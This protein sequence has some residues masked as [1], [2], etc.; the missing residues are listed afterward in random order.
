MLKRLMKRGET[1]GRADDNVETIKK[2]FGAF[3][4]LLEPYYFLN[5][6]TPTATYKEATMP[7]IEHY[8]KQGKV[9]EVRLECSLSLACLI[10]LIRQIDSSPTVAE[11]HK[12][13]VAA[14]EKVLV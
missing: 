14:V 7:V 11:V 10:L 6:F 4:S 8:E 9:A 2:R 13:A 3:E 12:V 1:S 5:L